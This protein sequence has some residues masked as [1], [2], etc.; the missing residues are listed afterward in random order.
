MTPAKWICRPPKS[1]YLHDPLPLIVPLDDDDPGAA[2]ILAIREALAS[3]TEPVLVLFSD[4]DPIFVPRVGER[5]VQSIQGAR[6][7]EIVAGAGHFLQED[8]PAEVATAIIA[9]L[10]RT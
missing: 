2:K 3:W 8:A 7:V 6:P 9:F 5:F 1:T 4:Q 10:N